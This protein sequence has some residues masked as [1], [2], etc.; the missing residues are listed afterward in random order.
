MEFKDYI[1][2]I[3]SLAMLI[4][5]LVTLGRN[6]RKERKAEYV[7]E[8]TKIHDIEQSLIRVNTKLDQLCGLMTE[9]KADVKAMNNGLQ[10]LDKRL[11]KVEGEQKTM[12]MRIDELKQKVGHYREGE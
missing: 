9:T 1:P 5:S 7:E 10:E 8:S 6:G 12:W 3:I 11:V 2:W 4:I